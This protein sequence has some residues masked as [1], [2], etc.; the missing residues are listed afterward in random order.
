[1]QC[2]VKTHP[3]VCQ[4]ELLNKEVMLCQPTGCVRTGQHVGEVTWCAVLP[5]I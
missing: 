3:Q 1:M 4:W 2:G 5:G